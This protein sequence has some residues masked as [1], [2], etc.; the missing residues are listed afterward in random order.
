MSRVLRVG[1]LIL[2]VVTLCSRPADAGLADWLEQLSGPGP[3]GSDGLASFVSNV[4]C[5][6]PKITLSQGDKEKKPCLYVDFHKFIND[7]DDEFYKASG[8]EGKELRATA[9]ALGV[10]FQPSTRLHTDVGVDFGRM[11]FHT[12]ET[13]TGHWTFAA[14]AQVKPLLF[15]EAFEKDANFIPWRKWVSVPKVYLRRS[16][17]LGTINGARDFGAIGSGAAYERKNEGVWSCGILLDFSELLR[18]PR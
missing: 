6:T 8:Q 2:S 14:R 15:I 4:V 13:D 3:F 10:A 9:Y 1:W 18:P 17:I 7:D 11:T 16:V 12:S 5:I